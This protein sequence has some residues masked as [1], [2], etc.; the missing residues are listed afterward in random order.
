M[1]IF[2]FNFFILFILLNFSAIA[3]TQED[4]KIVFL[5]SINFHDTRS[6]GVKGAIILDNGALPYHLKTISES[7]KFL[8]VDD[9]FDLAINNYYEFDTFNVHSDKATVKFFDSHKRNSFKLSFEKKG[10]SWE[11]ISIQNINN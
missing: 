7:I 3:Q 6:N 2:R 11:I 9:M 4:E 10:N 8:T 1:Y 5:K